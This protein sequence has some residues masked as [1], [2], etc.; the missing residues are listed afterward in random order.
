M[1][2]P[3]K[4]LLKNTSPLWKCSTWQGLSL[5]KRRL[6]A[7]LWDQMILQTII[8]SKLQFFLIKWYHLRLF[9]FPLSLAG[10][11]STENVWP[12]LTQLSADADALWSWVFLLVF[13]PEEELSMNYWS[14]LSEEGGV[15]PSSTK[16][17]CSAMLHKVLMIGVAFTEN[18]TQGN[19]I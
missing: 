16:Q 15:L 4:K 2:N 7:Y 8:S 6:L 10:H 12:N 13:P 11:R 3:L 19:K 18:K 17:F 14:W 9:P 1:P 5:Q